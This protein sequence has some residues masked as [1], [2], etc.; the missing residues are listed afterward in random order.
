MEIFL[1]IIIFIYWALFWSFWS[2]IIHRLK[3]WEK[4]ILWWRSHCNSCNTKLKYYDLVPILSWLSTFW[5]CRYCKSSISYVYPSLEIFNWILFL[6]ISI[7]LV[8]IN[9]IILLDWTEIIKL[10]FWLIIWFIT[11][12]YIF[13]DILFLEIHEWIMLSWIIIAILWLIANEW[14]LNIIPYMN[15]FN[16]DN[17]LIYNLFFIPLAF[18]IIWLLYI[19]MLKELE[20]KY[21]IAILAII[22]SIIS[23]Y[24]NITWY[25]LNEFPLISW[26]VWALGIFIFFFLQIVLSGWKALWWW[27]LRI[28]IMIWL[29]LGVSYSIAWMM[30]TYIVW[31]IISIF[32]IINKY[33][34][35]KKSKIDTQVAFWPFLW[36]GFFITVLFI[37]YIDN[38]IEIYF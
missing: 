28:W 37:N 2:V 3:S 21:D 30:I 20:I 12:L 27:D 31:S 25:S 33:I 17:F 1:Y 18:I 19:I 14:F 23:I 35:T 7:F 15:D 4:W 26:I 36:I 24:I 38:F 5:K 16:N 34:K 32:L 29:L 9:N 22:I 6:A 13:Y 11:T 10:I 8:D